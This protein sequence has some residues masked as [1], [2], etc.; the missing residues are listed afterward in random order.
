[1]PVGNW[2]LRTIGL[3][4]EQKKKKEKEKKKKGKGKR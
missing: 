2:N 1:M 4:W 3:K